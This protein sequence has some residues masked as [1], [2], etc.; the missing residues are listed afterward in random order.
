[1]DPQPQEITTTRPDPSSLT[2]AQLFREIARLERDTA[3]KMA[4]Q[5]ELIESKRDGDR[6]EN[7]QRFKAIDDRFEDSNKAVEA[8]FDAAKEAVAKAETLSTKLIDALGAR[9]D[10]VLQRVISRDGA[11][12]GMQLLWGLIG[13]AILIGI[14]ALTFFRGAK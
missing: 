12:K 1:M 14:A 6:R 9:I 10:D 5:L 3:D 4:A 8:A 11:E 2:T 7:A 13:G